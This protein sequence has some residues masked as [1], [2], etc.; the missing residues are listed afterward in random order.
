MEQ[1]ILASIRRD[2]F[3]DN[4]ILDYLLV[5]K[6]SDLKSIKIRAVVSTT[7]KPTGNLYDTER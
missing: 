4:G 1:K 3:E 7:E 2:T 5:R 6:K